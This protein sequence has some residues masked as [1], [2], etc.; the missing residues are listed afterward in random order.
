MIDRDKSDGS[1]GEIGRKVAA[2]GPI[3]SQWV[4]SMH[5]V[6]RR[7]GLV[8]GHRRRRSRHEMDLKVVFR[9]KD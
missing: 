3:I 2:I 5:A 8:G 7:E 6:G 4:H 1:V 9:E